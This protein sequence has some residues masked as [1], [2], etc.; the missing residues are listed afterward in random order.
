ME[1]SM[2]KRLKLKII[3]MF[4]SQADFA[5]AIKEDESVVSRIIRGRRKL[6]DQQKRK[7]AAALDCNPDQ[8]FPE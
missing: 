5:Q 4:G 2:N 8:I 1:D 6:D 3:E 7:W